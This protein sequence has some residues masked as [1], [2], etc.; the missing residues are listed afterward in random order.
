ME[1]SSTLS[2][3]AKKQRHTAKGDTFAEADNVD[4]CLDG[5]HGHCIALS[6]VV[7]FPFNLER[8]KR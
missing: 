8:L 1:H 4:E 7:L 2:I 3:S 6:A 5:L